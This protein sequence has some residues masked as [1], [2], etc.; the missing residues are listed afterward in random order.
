[1]NGRATF[2]NCISSKGNKYSAV[3]SLEEKDGYINL[4]PE[5]FIGDGKEK[6]NTP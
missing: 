1:M 4:K 3:F 2:N 5:G 6:K